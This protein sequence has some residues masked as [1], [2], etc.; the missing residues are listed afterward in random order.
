MSPE[1]TTKAAP[2]KLRTAVIGVGGMGGGHCTQIR[3]KVRE[4]K[5]V[6]VCDADPTIAERV[7]AQFRVPFFTSHRKL[8]KSGLCDAITI[9]TPHPLHAPIAVDCMNAGLHVLT[10]KPV[11]DRISA[12][13]KMVR[14]SKKNKVAFAVMFQRRFSPAFSKALGI[15]KKGELGRVLRAT[16]ISPEYRSQAYYDSGGWRATW[17]GEGGGVMMNQSPHIMDMFVH[18][19]G[20]PTA[21]RGR[22]ETRLH[23]IEVEDVAEAALTYDGGGSGCF[24]CSTNEPGPGQMIEVF[25]EKGKLTLR[26]GTVRFFRYKQ[27]ISDFTRSSTVK[28]AGPPTEEVNVKLR[29]RPSG[30]FS[31]LRNFARHILQGE[32]LLCAGESGLASLE[33]ANA[34]T[35]SS[36]LGREVKIPISRRAYDTLLSKLRKESTFQKTV[37]ANRA[38]D[39]Q[40]KV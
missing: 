33:L 9:A 30:H 3:T 20:M 22:T 38:M 12:A 40:H 21:V 34:I 18:L 5:L 2:A 17:G 16:L 23:D 36:Y 10:E 6:A 31:V 39:P 29:A 37:T 4:M 1:N 11:C 24:Y 7:G 15:V 26:D 8:I 14:A 32:E 19:A 35:L 13:E 28:W 27:T 25:G